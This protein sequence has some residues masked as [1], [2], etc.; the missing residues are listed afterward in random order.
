[1][2][3]LAVRVNGKK[4]NGVVGVDMDYE[5]FGKSNGMMMVSVTGTA[6]VVE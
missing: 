1:V 6:V 4:V 3:L 5:C 2:P